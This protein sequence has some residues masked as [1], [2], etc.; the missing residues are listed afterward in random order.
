MTAANNRGIESDDVHIV[1]EAELFL[2]QT[3]DDPELGPLQV[4][5]D[6]E[7]DGIV[8]RFTMDIDGSGIVGSEGVV[9]PKVI[10]EPAT[11]LCDSDQF[12]AAR[13]VDAEFGLLAA[14]ED[15]FN[16][17]DALEKFLDPGEIFVSADVNVSDLMVRYG[18][19]FR[20]SA[21]ESFP[22]EGFATDDEIA[23]FPEDAIEVDRL[24]DFRDAVLG[25]DDSF[26]TDRIGGLDDTSDFGVDQF[27]LAVDRRGFGA[28]PLEAV[29]EVREIDQGEGGG[30]FADEVGTHLC[31]PAT[32]GDVGSGSPEFQEG[33]EA[34]AL[35]VFVPQFGGLTVGVEDLASV[36]GIAGSR[37]HRPG[38]GGVHVVPPEEFGGG[39]RGIA[40]EGGL[41]DPFGLNEMVRLFPEKNFGEVAAVPAVGDNAVLAGE[42]AGEECGLRGAGDGRQDGPQFRDE[43]SLGDGVDLGRPVP[44]HRRSQTYDIQNDDGTRHVVIDSGEAPAFGFM[45]GLVHESGLVFE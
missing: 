31:D 8:S 29:V 18:E 17:R 27:D 6:E 38:D 45:Q 23:R 19:G 14:I 11:G 42:L 41:V 7:F 28:E 20:G 21:V 9:L 15:S 13:V 5:V 44:Q 33:K 1:P 2:E 40:S 25:E 22:A 32:A 16:S 3:A 34:V 39:V 37:G 24:R 26:R 10:G 4:R 35:L 30:F 36:G 12:P 43:A